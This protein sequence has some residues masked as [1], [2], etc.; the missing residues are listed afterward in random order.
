MPVRPVLF[1]PILLILVACGGGSG[2]VALSNGGSS[3]SGGPSSD[4]TAFGPE[5]QVTLFGHSEDAM[6]PFIARDGQTLFFNNSNAPNVDTDL[7][8]A[9]RQ[10][11]GSFTSQGRIAG[12]NSNALDGV[13]SMD[14]AGNFYF[15]SVRSYDSSL[16]TLY[17]GRFAQ[18]V[19]SA[20]TIVPG[21]SRLERGI[22]NFDAEISS[23]GNSLWLV[24]GRFSGGFLPDTAAIV[25]AERQGSGFVSRADS[26][27]LLGAINTN[28]LNYAPSISADG[29]ELFFTRIADAANPSPVIYRATRTSASGA[30]GAPQRISAITGFAEAPSLSAD[31]RTLFYHKR[32]GNVFRIFSVSR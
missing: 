20:P 24:D 25:L 5:T 16:A 13:A 12:A 23:D 14:S 22:L 19:L 8:W 1:L 15:V 21:I 32:V 3:S 27:T 18:G 31:G 9:T 4:Y 17:S 28:G 26:A 30:F 10:A 2:A 7:F 6:E 29:L 11:D